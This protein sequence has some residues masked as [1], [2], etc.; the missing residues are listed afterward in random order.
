MPLSEIQRA[1]CLEV[2]P[3]LEEESVDLAIA[4][5]PYWKVVGQ[6]WDYKWRTVEDY[7]AWCER[8]CVEVY[9]AL[10]KGGSFYLFGY[11]RMLAKLVSPLERLGFEVR[12]QVILKKGRKAISGRKTST[13]KMFP[14]ETES[15]LFC[16]KDAKPW[17]REFLKEKR[18][19]VGLS[20]RE[21]NEALGVKSNGGGMWSIWTGNNVDAQVPTEEMWKALAKVL[22]FRYPYRKVGQTFHVELG[23]TDVWDDVE[24]Y[25]WKRLHPTQKPEELIERIV[26]A[27]S[28]EGDVVVD[29]FC[30]AG[31]VPVV[32]E[33]LGREWLATETN[34]RYVE[35]ARKRIRDG[36]R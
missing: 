16:V 26:R 27:S 9:R 10:R 21:I 34:P 6:K 22:K 25:G 11:F 18:E 20:A 4:D 15:I 24:F 28:N 7:L 12:Q 13:Y 19:K 31:T 35:L 8:W 23:L 33:R 2:L 3:T 14:V 5:P 36:R 30:G 29:P 17:V 32:C 1:D